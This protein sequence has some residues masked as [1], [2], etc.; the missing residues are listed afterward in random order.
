MNNIAPKKL[1]TANIIRTNLLL[2]VDKELKSKK[3]LT[4]IINQLNECSYNDIVTFEENFSSTSSRGNDYFIKKK[5]GKSW[6]SQKVTNTE[7]NFCNHELVTK[8]LVSRPLSS[9]RSN[10]L[11]TD[12]NAISQFK[13]SNN[14]VKSTFKAVSSKNVNLSEQELSL[15]A[16]ETLR[17]F[18]NRGKS[19]KTLKQIRSNKSKSP[20][21][22]APSTICS[23]TYSDCGMSETLSLPDD[24][25]EGLILNLESE[26]TLK[27]DFCS[28]RLKEDVL[29][30]ENPI[31]NIIPCEE[32]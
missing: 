25:I 27:L 2:S 15:N 11:V 32:F 13:K 12:H 22:K 21:K 6:S 16:L 29:K 18:A 5:P 30:G 14:F 10:Y 3:S 4:G 28:L 8:T 26:R 23:Q 1:K 31:I 9:V 19:S 17:S 7:D 20:D 24:L